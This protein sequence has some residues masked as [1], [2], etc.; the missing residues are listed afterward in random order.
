MSGEKTLY[1]LRVKENMTLREAAE[2]IGIDKSTLCRYE[3]LMPENIRPEVMEGICRVY[4]VSP[5]VF[6]EDASAACPG[7]F[8][9][10]TPEEAGEAYGRLEERARLRVTDMIL[11]ELNH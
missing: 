2:Q 1:E 5:D 9:M 11:R 6:S 10:L 3:Q 8:R 7:W 4:R